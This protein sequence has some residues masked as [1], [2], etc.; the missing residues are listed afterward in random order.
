[1]SWN[2]NAPSW[3]SSVD[4]VPDT[5][6]TSANSMGLLA[7]HSAMVSPIMFVRLRLLSILR[8]MCSFPALLTLLLL[9]MI[10]ILSS[11]KA[12]DDDL[13]WHLRNAEYLVQTHQLPNHD[14]YSFT[15]AGKDWINYEWLSEIPF[16]LAWRLDGLA[17]VNILW[18]MLVQVIFAGLLYLSYRCSANFKASVLACGFCSFLA[19]VSFGPRTVL[20]GYLYMVLLL[21]ILERFRST[22][23]APL[24][25]VPPLFCVWINSH[26]SWLIGFIVFSIVAGSGLIEGRWGHVESHRW[27]PS[28]FRQLVVAGLGSALALFINPFGWRLLIYPFQFVSQLQGQLG[29]F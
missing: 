10:W 16:Y 27:T 6:K 12:T 17:G 2:S 25:L 4:A 13:R 9:G 23:R 21:I 26:T 3:C 15:V 11:S 8:V 7:G 24:L 14:I 18:M 5:D 28:Q 1:S 29:Y 19:V 20:F 22:G